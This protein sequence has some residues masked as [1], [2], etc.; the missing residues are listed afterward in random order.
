MLAADDPTRIVT[1]LDWE[2]ST[3]GD[4]LMDLGTT[5]SYWVEADDSEAQL[6]SAFGPTMIA[7]SMTRNQLVE[8]YTERTGIGIPSILFYYCFGLFKLAVIV[9]QIYARYVR[10]QTT[11]SRFAHL[12]TRV[13]LLGKT[14]IRAI[15]TGSL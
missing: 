6:Q 13:A 7:G 2:M 12:N 14:A 3:V 8:R 9:Q 5:L 10:G 1:V 15:R 4:P 11:D